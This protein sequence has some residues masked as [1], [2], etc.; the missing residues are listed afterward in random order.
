MNLSTR[1]SRKFSNLI[2]KRNPITNKFDIGKLKS[3]H[4]KCLSEIGWFNSEI[5]VN[6]RKKMPNASFWDIVRDPNNLAGACSLINAADLRGR[7]HKF[8]FDAGW[9]H[10][11]MIKIFEENGIDK[12]LKNKEIE[13]SFISHEHHD[14]FLGIPVILKYFPNI[15]LYLP[16]T[17]TEKAYKYI[18]QIPFKTTAFINNLGKHTGPI[19]KISQQ[20]MMQIGNISG[21]ASITFDMKLDSELHGESTIFA[22]I[23]DKGIIIL[24]GCCHYGINET[25]KFA[26]QNIEGGENIY[27][28]YGGLHLGPY[29]KPL[30]GC[31][32]QLC[33]LKKLNIPK[34]GANHCTGAEVIDIMIKKKFNIVKGN[35]GNKYIK[36]G[37]E[38]TF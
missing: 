9:S 16:E 26:Q 5:Y 11:Y 37:C 25:I 23:E 20:N 17:F 29:G 19:Y 21:L 34:I 38:F 22:N 1:L 30:K 14:H 4:V 28:V 3:L 36:S 2:I 8:L 33:E 15:P 24:T 35:N 18:R 6:E 10:S 31:D 32:S 13:F 7:S 27:G 12:M